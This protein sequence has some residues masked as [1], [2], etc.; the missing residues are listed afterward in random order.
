MK[1]DETAVIVL[2]ESDHTLDQ[3]VEFY[4]VLESDPDVQLRPVVSTTERAWTSGDFKVHVSQAEQTTLVAI[5][6]KAK[7]PRP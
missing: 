7:L 5:S 3:L 4:R 1:G 6:G 2:F